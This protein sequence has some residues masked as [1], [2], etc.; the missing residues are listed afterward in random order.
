ML[1]RLV[2]LGGCVLALIVA[3][4]FWTP[5]HPDDTAVGPV[6]MIGAVA[7]AAASVWPRLL[8]G[9]VTWI[10]VAV[11]T[12]AGNGIGLL[13]KR[14]DI[15]CMYTVSEHYGYPSS[16]IGKHADYETLTQNAPPA[17]FD[18]DAAWSVNWFAFLLANWYW[19]CIA[20]ALVGL[21][22]AGISLARRRTALAGSQASVA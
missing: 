19:A 18:S 13:V 22:R 6:L 3:V 1:T 12:V 5:S 9:W 8:M 16:W 20:V 14:S 11:L 7:L 2:F 15:C 21:V 10:A 17:T 4:L